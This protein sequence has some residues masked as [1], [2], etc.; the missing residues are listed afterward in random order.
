M[1]GAF[2]GEMAVLGLGLGDPCSSQSCSDP[3]WDQGAAPSLPEN[4]RGWHRQD[5]ARGKRPGGDVSNR[6]FPPKKSENLG[7]MKEQRSFQVCGQPSV[8]AS[9]SLKVSSRPS[10]GLFKV[11]SGFLLKVFLPDFEGF[12]REAWHKPA[13]GNACSE[14]SDL[15][16]T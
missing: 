6:F 4:S 5:P 11:P 12:Q 3:H 16:P 1:E 7:K 15:W 9:Q 10:R 13:R 14:M 2:P 8:E